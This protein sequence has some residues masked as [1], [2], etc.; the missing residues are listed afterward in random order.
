ARERQE[1]AERA[2]KLLPQLEEIKGHPTGKPSGKHEAR[3]ST[4]DPE[5]RRMKRGD[6]SIGPAY[7]VQFGVDTDSRAI[8]NAS[9]HTGGDDQSQST[10]MREGVERR[11][12]AAV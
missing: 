8:L 12:G 4:T 11:T 6:G 1:R 5:A 9:V 2:L 7:N 3:V 10:P